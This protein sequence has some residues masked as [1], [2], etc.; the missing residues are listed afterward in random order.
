[1]KAYFLLPATL[2]WCSLCLANLFGDTALVRFEFKEPHMGTLFKIILYSKDEQTAQTAA[3]AAF[4]HIAQLDQIMSDYKPSSELMQLCKKAGGDPVQV[5]RDLYTILERAQEVARK[6]DGAFDVTIGPVVRLW[7]KARRLG[8]LP[9]AE[10]LKN[11][12]AVVGYEKLKLDSTR[13]AVQL[14]VTGILLDLGGIAKGYA[15][16]AALEVLRQHGIRRAL[17][18]AGGDVAV[19]D[20]PPGAKGWKIGI[21]PLK[22]PKGEPDQHLLLSNAAVSTSGDIHQYV[23]IKGKRYSH[24]VDPATGLGLAGRRSVTVIARDGITA[25]SWATAL[26]VMGPERA[27]RAIQ[28]VPGA[29]MQY[30]LETTTGVESVRSRGF[31]AFTIK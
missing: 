18:A 8:Q 10:E 2:G 1:M 19:G 27:L 26:S 22:D 17:V 11:A 9:S 21:A 25:D 20:C 16:D 13:R 24:V 5:S 12:L 7:R 31:E 29:E 14:L 23:E 28:T 15:A 3:K 4:A 30:T 6:S